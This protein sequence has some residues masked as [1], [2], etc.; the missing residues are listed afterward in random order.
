MFSITH[1]AYRRYSGTGGC[2]QFYA[3]GSTSK[4]NQMAHKELQFIRHLKLRCNIHHLNSTYDM[5][6][7][8]LVVTVSGAEFFTKFNLPVK[9]ILEYVFPKF[10]Y[11][12]SAE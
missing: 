8:L 7:Q 1:A 2:S 12:Q 6:E 10:L 4:S 9:I 11:E 3:Q 5:T